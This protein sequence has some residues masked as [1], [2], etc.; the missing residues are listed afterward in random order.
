MTTLC[1]YVSAMLVQVYWYINNTFRK[2]EVV[3]FVISRT[4]VLIWSQI[5]Y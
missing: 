2:T 4:T 1:Q 5:I 3:N